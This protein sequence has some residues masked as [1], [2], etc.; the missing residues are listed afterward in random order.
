[1]GPGDDIVVQF[2][3]MVRS[4]VRRC[5]AIVESHRIPRPL[6]PRRS[7]FPACFFALLVHVSPGKKQK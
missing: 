3:S 5:S 6:V 7:R 4:G 2:P 1:M